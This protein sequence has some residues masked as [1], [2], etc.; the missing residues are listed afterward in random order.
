MPE[1]G[2]ELTLK[3]R[4]FCQL[5]CTDKD[6]FANGVKSYM[7]AYGMMPTESNYN[8][9]KARANKLLQNTTLLSYCDKLL[10]L[11][12]L[13]D[14]EVDKQMQFWIKQRAY[15]SA[16]VAAIKEYNN[17]RKRINRFAGLS[18]G[19]TT[20]NW[21]ISMVD[22]AEDRVKGEVHDVPYEESKVKKLADEL[23]D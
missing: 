6:F 21:F 9:A 11:E 10:E 3:Q 17:L 20:H 19:G 15:P 7:K 2:R 13:N 4:Y 14:V 1:E 18:G 22:N 23:K 16:S 8:T 5:Y 12:G